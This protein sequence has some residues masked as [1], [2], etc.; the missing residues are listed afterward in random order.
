MEGFTMK[1]DDHLLN[2][3]TSNNEEGSKGDTTPDPRGRY[4]QQ[5]DSDVET[6][7]D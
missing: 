1:K 4:G 3:T 2:E 6:D 5:I 7:E